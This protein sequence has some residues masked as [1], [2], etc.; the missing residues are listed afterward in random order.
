M[1]LALGPVGAGADGPAPTLSLLDTATAAGWTQSQVIAQVLQ[2]GGQQPSAAN[3]LLTN[4]KRKRYSDVPVAPGL[5]GSVP[6]PQ[7]PPTFAGV[8]AT[9]PN[10]AQVLR[11]CLTFEATPRNRRGGRNRGSFI[12]AAHGLETSAFAT[13]GGMPVVGRLSTGAFV[14]PVV[15]S[16][17]P[18]RQRGSLDSG[19]VP[20]TPAFG[21]ASAMQAPPSRNPSR[22]RPSSFSGDAPRTASCHKCR[23]L[24][25]HCLKLY[26]EC[27]ANGIF[28]SGCSCSSCLNTQHN[29]AMVAEKR[30]LIQARNPSA[31]QP[32]VVVAAQGGLVTPA[33]KTGC[34]CKKSAC[35]KRYCECYEAGVLC[36]SHCKCEGCRNCDPKAG[37]GG[38][39]ASAGPF[40]LPPSR[41]SAVAPITPAPPVA[42]TTSAPPL[43]AHR[44]V[45]AEGLAAIALSPG[46]LTLPF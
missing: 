19:A 16:R 35:Q 18:R 4:V 39:G 2:P 41:V 40:K 11:R 34:R 33:H 6:L 38:S 17:V 20:E 36:G 43:N 14:T 8:A 45:T 31:F 46:L 42:F 1:P 13:P 23:C 5:E 27:F 10:S 9:S 37:G 26:C 3:A 22:P 32:R 25:S 30:A 24:K 7:G 29:S 15:S 28:C 44:L 21:A 12:A